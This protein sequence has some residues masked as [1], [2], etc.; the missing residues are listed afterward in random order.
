MIKVLFIVLSKNSSLFL[1]WQ[2]YN[3]NLAIALQ[4]G[5][6]EFLVYYLQIYLF[7][8]KYETHDSCSTH[9]RCCKL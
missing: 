3:K 9:L 7:N 6:D 1:F 5:K 2:V 8:S 4:Q